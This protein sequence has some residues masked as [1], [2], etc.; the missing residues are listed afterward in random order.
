MNNPA[1]ALEAA[2]RQLLETFDAHPMRFTLCARMGVPM[3]A[4]LD[5]LRDVLEG[6]D[7]KPLSD[8]VKARYQARMRAETLAAARG[9]R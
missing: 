1:L 5:D 4:A 8:A 9:S 3:C 6:R 2:A 7:P